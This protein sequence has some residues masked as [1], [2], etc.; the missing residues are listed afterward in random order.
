MTMRNSIRNKI[1]ILLGGLVL[2]ILSIFG[3]LRIYDTTHPYQVKYFIALGYNPCEVDFILTQEDAIKAQV[4]NEPYLPF[5]IKHLSIE[6]YTDLIDLGYTDDE[7]ELL[8]YLDKDKLSFILKNDKDENLFEWIQIETFIPSRY[9]RYIDASHYLA[10]DETQL[11]EWVNSNRDRAFYTEI[12]AS[13][14]ELGK[15]MLVN[16]YHALAEDFVPNELISIAPYGSVKLDREA[17]EAFKELASDAKDEGYT[18]VGI[19]GYR[20][21]QTQATL[22]QRYVSNDGK[23]LADTYSARAGHSEHQTGLAIDVASNNANILT[24][25]Q[26]RSFDWMFEHAYEYGF[27]LRYP[28]GKEQ[29]TGYKYEPWHYRY[30]GVDIATEIKKSG[31]TFDEYAAVYILD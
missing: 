2:I 29:I 21:Y 26:S 31:M 30:V 17:A 8:L 22:Y 6:N 7:A 1:L 27:I 24:F 20:S 10:F 13:F 3:G 11:F 4:L 18:I 25:E 12:Q 5:I 9:Q 16:K 19:S 15:L 23:Q 28:K 14:P